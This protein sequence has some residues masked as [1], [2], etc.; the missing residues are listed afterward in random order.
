M[1]RFDQSADLAERQSQDHEAQAEKGER[2]AARPR[3]GARAQQQAPGRAGRRMQARCG[4]L[5]QSWALRARHKLLVREVK[6]SRSA[7]V[8][9][10]HRRR[11]STAERALQEEAF[12]GPEPRAVLSVDPGAAGTTMMQG[13]PTRLTRAAFRA[14]IRK[15]L[16]LNRADA[17]AEFGAAMGLLGAGRSTPPLILKS[18]TRSG[19]R[20]T[21]T[22]RSPASRACKY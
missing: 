18:P 16:D 14:D 3:R 17:A 13:R 2:R 21:R 20:T 12:R 19:S 15:A 4:R 9:L 8:L 22:R 5:W 1:V 10:V 6:K 11:G 7:Q